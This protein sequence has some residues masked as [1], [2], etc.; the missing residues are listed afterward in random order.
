MGVRVRSP[1]SCGELVQGTIDRENFLV[2]CPVDLYSIVEITTGEQIFP[3]VGIKTALAVDRTAAYFGVFSHDFQITV[4]SQLSSGKGMASSSA[5]IAA[6]CQATALSLGKRLTADEIADIALSIEPTDG[7]FYP[8]IMMFDHVHGTIRR[9]LGMPPAM[10]IA[11]FDVGGEIDTLRF[12]RRKDLAALN[13]AKEYQVHKA[14][15]LVQRGLQTNNAGLI[16]KGATLSAL[17]N[18]HILF[19]PCLNQIIELLSRFGAV[20]VNAAHSGT[21]I[22]VLFPQDKTAN[23]QQFIQ[24][25]QENCSEIQYLYTVRLISGGLTV[26]EGDAGESQNAI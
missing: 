8:G 26:L 9:S 2:T 6:A 17:A 1:G 10:S 25:V 20:G 5:D 19:K 18:Q 21:V 7:V 13:Q 15:E 12:N 3:K 11:V 14:L 23:L 4:E 22:G 24:T 16:G